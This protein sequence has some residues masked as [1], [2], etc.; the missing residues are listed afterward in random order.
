MTRQEE[1]EKARIKKIE[2]LRKAGIEPYPYS[3]DR[4]DYSSDIKQKYNALKNNEI[5]NENVKVAGRVVAKRLIG[6]IAFCHILD[7]KGKLQIVFEKSKNKTALD[8]FEK[9][10]DVGDFIGVE[11]IPYKTK[12]G[13]TSVIALNVVMLA[14]SLKPLPE[15]WHGLKDVELRYRKR[16]LDLIMNDEV[17][18]LF[19]KRTKII[20]AIREFLN[21][22]GYIEVETPILQEVYGGAAARP[23]V[24]F[25]NALKQ[26]FFLRIS[27]ELYLKRLVIG[28]FEKVYEIARNFRNEGIDANHNPEFTMIEFYEAYRD[29]EYM[30]ELTK[31]LICYVVDI[32]GQ[33]K[34]KWRDYEID[35]NDWQKITMQEAF[36]KYAN[37][38]IDALSDD[39][40]KQI[41]EQHNVEIEKAATRGV[42]I[43]K[44][45]EALVQ[46]HLINPTFIMDY[47]IDIS[48][49]TKKHRKK[50]G[51]VERWELFI[52]GMEVANAYSELNDPIDQEQR[53]K[54][55]EEARKKGL[56]EEE[57]WPTDNEFVDALKYGMPP[58]GG[59]GLGI[60]RLVMLITG[61]SSIREVILFPH[62]KR[63]TEEE[64]TKK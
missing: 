44:L 13:E 36:K 26:N 37:I 4:T 55:Q 53:F 1:I 47:P 64:K 20:N 27:P 25:F 5:A 49:L 35:F 3:F 18:E 59:V 57:A 62:L 17:K 32:V 15:K 22:K 14:K 45:F 41:A 11:G 2:E 58:C 46:P 63:K 60:D 10:I 48:P 9:Y 34:V 40:L 7:A 42:I 6:S 19:T 29:Y 16:Y 38:D 21:T 12:R 33:K 39:E 28:N 8:F 52:G 31:E 30:A 24:T 51:Y 61:A 54:Q 56:S 50:Q 23:F 43:D